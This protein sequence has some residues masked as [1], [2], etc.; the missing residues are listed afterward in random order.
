MIT[1]KEQLRDYEELRREQLAWLFKCEGLLHRASDLG[2]DKH[3]DNYFK[4]KN[5]LA[6]IDGF[7][8]ILKSNLGAKK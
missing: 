1:I 4:A 8:K 5:N 2:E 3:I 7:I 6:L